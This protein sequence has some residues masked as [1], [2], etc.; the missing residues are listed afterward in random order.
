M[1]GR[2]R[3]E[4]VPLSLRQK[5]IELIQEA[6]KAGARLDNACNE[7][8]LSKRTYRRWSKN[9]E[10]QADFRPTAKRTEPKNKLTE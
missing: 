8:P 4:L 9:G 10:V 6:C 2:E 5:L 7:V 3:G 1:G